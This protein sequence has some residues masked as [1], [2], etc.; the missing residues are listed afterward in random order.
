MNRKELHSQIDLLIERLAANNT[1]LKEHEGK[2][3]QLETDLLRKQCIELYDAINQLHMVNMMDKSSKPAI[4]KTPKE[5]V[6]KDLE[7]SKIEKAIEPELPKE[8]IIKEP[9][10]KKE[11]PEKEAEIVTEKKEEELIIRIEE[12][13]SKPHYDPPKF[14]PIVEKPEPVITP[15]KKPAEP[16]KSVLDKINEMKSNVS[17]HESISSKSEEN[18]LSHRFANSKIEKIKDA[19]DI[20]KRFEIQSNLFLADSNAFNIS[21]SELENAEDRASAI[22]LF[23]KFALRYHWKLEDELVQELKSFIYRKY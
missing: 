17:L 16:E 14:V 12:Q 19:I 7:T 15:P 11:E 9:E 4:D 18:E 23:N 2:F 8:E 5:S 6:I 1:S 20:S 21:I 10:L 3:S 22:E 13:K